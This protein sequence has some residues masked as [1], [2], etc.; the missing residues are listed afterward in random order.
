MPTKISRFLI[1]LGCLSPM[2]G[3]GFLVYFIFLKAALNGLYSVLSLFLLM[4]FFIL[5]ATKI[6]EKRKEK[7]KNFLL[8]FKPEVDGFQETQSF[9]SFDLLSKIAMDANKECLYLWA[10]ENNDAKAQKNV[11]YGMPYQVL[12]YKYSDILAVEMFE[13]K[14]PIST[15]SRRSK[16]ARFLLDGLEIATDTDP[17][18]MEQTKNKELTKIEL[19]LTVNDSI[20]PIHLIRFYFDPHKSLRK[21]SI[22]YQSIQND[23]QHWFTALHLIIKNS[24]K[25]DGFVNT[26]QES[27]LKVAEHEQIV[28]ATS[29]LLSVLK[30][31][32]HNK[33]NDETQFNFDSKIEQ[34]KEAPSSYFDELLKKNRKQLHGHSDTK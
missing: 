4:I 29:Q 7:Q 31:V 22:E 10:P 9:I 27:G 12:T 26:S 8:T 16:S 14:I 25:K 21:E 24:D 13:N 34:S 23:L 5:L 30:K 15:V 1:G 6:E 32:L 33:L 28:N 2:V 20:K 11:Y 3:I 17:L 19:K 18:Q